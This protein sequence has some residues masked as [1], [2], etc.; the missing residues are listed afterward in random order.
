MFKLAILFGIAV[1][2]VFCAPHY[3]NPVYDG[4]YGY[5]YPVATS[6]GNRY[7]YYPYSKGKFGHI[8]L[9]KDIIVV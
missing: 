1:S 8:Y 7:D 4:Y 5:N 3:V 9:Q 6:Y 2:A